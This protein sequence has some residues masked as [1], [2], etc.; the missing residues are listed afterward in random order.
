MEG[1]SPISAEE[2]NSDL[3]G[4]KT[5]KMKETKKKIIIA[6]GIAL[7]V[8][9]LIVLIIIFS[10]LGKS[11][12]DNEIDDTEGKEIL[13]EIECIYYVQTLSQPTNI[14]GNDN[15]VITTDYDKLLEKTFIENTISL[16]IQTFQVILYIP[17]TFPYFYLFYAL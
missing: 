11:S 12:S 5:E 1:E 17:F 2:L 6:V 14:I 3:G 8:I 9:I 4:I 16:F 7:I 15:S 13:G 10:T